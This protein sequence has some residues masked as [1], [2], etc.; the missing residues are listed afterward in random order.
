M[1]DPRSLK[2]VWETKEPYVGDLANGYTAIRIPV[3]RNK[4]MIYTIVAP[5]DPLF[6]KGILQRALNPKNV[7]FVITGSNGVVITASDESKFTM[8]EPLQGQLTKSLNG[9]LS[10]K[11]DLYSKPVAIAYGGWKIIVF[12]PESS[13]GAPFFKLRTVVLLIGALSVVLAT[14]LILLLSNALTAKEKAIILRE[15]LEAQYETQL[16]VNEAVKAANVGLWDWNLITNQVSYSP[17]WKNQ[18]GYED[19]EIG[20]DYKQWEERVHPDDLKQTLEKVQKSISELRQDHQVEFRFKHKDGS[21][22]W[23][24][25]HASI[26]PDQDGR[27]ARML[28]SHIDITERKK[29]ENELRIKDAAIENSLNGFNIVNQDGE[30]VY[31]NKAFVKMYGYGNADELYSVSPVHLCEDPTLPEK[32]IKNIKE[33]GEYIFEHRAN[34]KDGTTFDILMYARLAHDENGNEIYP[35]TSIDI[36]EQKK[37]ARDKEILQKKLSHAQKMESIGQL[38]GGIAHD[39][40]NILHPIM[41]FTQLSQS[42]LPKDHPVQENLIDILNGAKR[43]SELVKRILHF[44]RQKEPELKPIKLQTVIKETQ[45]LLRSTIPSGIDLRINLYD[46]QDAVLCDDSEIHEILL[47]LCTNSFHAIPGDQGEIIIGLN[48][49]KPSPDLDLPPGEYLCLS[50]KDNGIGISERI[51]DKIFE[52]YITTKDVGKGSGLGL[53]VVYGIVKNYNG[54]IS[55][56]SSPKTGTL[57]EIFI[58][59]TNQAVEAEKHEFIFDLNINGGNHILFVDDEEAIVKLGCR[60][61]E[62]FGYRVTGIEDSRKALNLFKENPYDFDLVITD[63]SMPNM[64]GSEL[65]QKLLEIRSDIPII[66]CSGYSEKLDRMKAKDLKVSA[67]LDKPLSFDE[68]QKVVST[69]LNDQ[70]AT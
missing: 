52:P 33:N 49:K 8:G 45:K 53:S 62:K 59:I 22:R 67:F 3:T 9:I 69:V 61:L 7:R 26:F 14:I 57:F 5:V 23:I 60:V 70:K 50:V 30:L 29:Y 36:T 13:V 39:F 37:A 17:E 51:K 55:V 54:D 31:V 40:N 24:L 20:N 25:A 44:S 58:P 12:T 48:R 34:R 21:Y 10:V 32:V 43:A 63:M 2:I 11:G 18:I 64:V 6:F 65:S 41:G 42:E 56:E 66:I 68:L 19:H 16:R 15:Q 35:T 28:G 46:G 1:R 27:P 47:N 38:A 4:R